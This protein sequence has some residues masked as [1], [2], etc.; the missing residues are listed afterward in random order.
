MYTKTAAMPR[1]GFGHDLDAGPT[2]SAP[3]R[4]LEADLRERGPLSHLSKGFRERWFLGSLA[5]QQRP[6]SERGANLTPTRTVDVTP[7]G[8]AESLFTRATLDGLAVNDKCAGDDGVRATGWNSSSVKGAPPYATASPRLRKAG[9]D[10]ADIGRGCRL[11]GRLAESA[12]AVLGFDIA[13]EGICRES[14]ESGRGARDRG[15]G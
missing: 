2:L 14:P 13:L 1:I 9:V 5:W 8:G 12:P 7:S 10:L 4:G 15:S 3:A 6:E 11:G